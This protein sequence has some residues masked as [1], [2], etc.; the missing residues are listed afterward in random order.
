MP[1][2]RA[3]GG[4]AHVRVAIARTFFRRAHLKIKGGVISEERGVT[5]TN[6]F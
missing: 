5:T 3:S 6:N 2:F 4:R 1:D